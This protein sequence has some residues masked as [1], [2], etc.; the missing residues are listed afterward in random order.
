MPP[1]RPPHRPSKARSP[2]SA[3]RWPPLP[4]LPIQ[5]QWGC[6]GSSG[7]LGTPWSFAPCRRMPPPWLATCNSISSYG[8]AVPLVG[9][10]SN[11]S[12]SGVSPSSM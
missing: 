11:P 9:W 3:P 7:R 4:R 12:S 1:P 2:R 10:M 6:S 5:R 8:C